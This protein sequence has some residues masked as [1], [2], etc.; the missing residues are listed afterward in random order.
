MSR[1]VPLL[2][3]LVS[4]AGCLERVATA[5]NAPEPVSFTVTTPPPEQMEA[6]AAHHP[7][8]PA[9]PPPVAGEAVQFRPAGVTLQL[10]R[11]YRERDEEP[12]DSTMQAW[13]D[14]DGTMLTLSAS[15]GGQFVIGGDSTSVHVEQGT[16]SVR[17]AGR[18][19]T[20]Q[21]YVL[22]NRSRADTLFVAV[23]DIPLR[24]HLWIGVGVVSPST[25]G[26]QQA[27]AAL[28]TLQVQ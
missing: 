25:A 18:L 22:V 5:S 19:S 15:D 13:E 16:C 14:A 28:G 8:C 3:L 26:R 24:Q 17:V 2:I 6:W 20:I 11:G 10:P 12:S 23:S 7:P 27:L 1:Y 9:L 4:A 21:Q